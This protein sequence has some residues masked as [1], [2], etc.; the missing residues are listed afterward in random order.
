MKGSFDKLID[1][2]P[3]SC[4]AHNP[5][6]I[7]LIRNGRLLYE[8]SFLR[9]L[10]GIRKHFRFVPLLIRD[11]GVILIKRINPMT[12]NGQIL[13]LKDPIPVHPSSTSSP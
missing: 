8:M 12:S 7:P 1:L 11:V 10:G 5:P 13:N 4:P 2:C 3:Q 6:L 9:T